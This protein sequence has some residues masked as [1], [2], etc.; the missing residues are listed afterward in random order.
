MASR[1]DQ[2]D[3]SRTGTMGRGP[4]GPEV[5]AGVRTLAE[6]ADADNRWGRDSV[7]TRGGAPANVRPSRR[8]TWEPER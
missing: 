8:A 2:T 6:E 3:S 5:D 7:G 4:L 1:D